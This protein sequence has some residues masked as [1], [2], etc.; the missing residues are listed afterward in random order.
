VEDDVEV[1]HEDPVAVPVALDRA[2]PQP[3]VRPQA[4]PDLVVDR[5]CLARVS[6]RAE[7][8]EV[9]VGGDG[10]QIE[11]QDVLCQLLLGESGDAAGLFE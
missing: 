1:V 6:P 3:L 11:D 7:D 8:E 4:L 9:G 2:R 5:L 10:P